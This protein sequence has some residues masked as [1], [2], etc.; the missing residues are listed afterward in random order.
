[1]ASPAISF[2]TGPN[3]WAATHLM[4]QS[5]ERF[6]ALFAFQCQ[7]QT[8]PK[9]ATIGNCRKG[10]REHLNEGVPSEGVNFCPVQFFLVFQ[11]GVDQ[12]RPR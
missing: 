3:T 1:M 11:T 5:I 7:W 4:R 2:M 8:R 6:Q 10:I 9:H 12:N